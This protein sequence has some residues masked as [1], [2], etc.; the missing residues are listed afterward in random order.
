MLYSI[1]IYH[2]LVPNVLVLLIR[3]VDTCVLLFEPMLCIEPRLLSVNK[4]VILVISDVYNGLQYGKQTTLNLYKS[5]YQQ[6]IKTK[7]C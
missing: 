4:L 2:T 6:Y 5:V 7:N 1:I 3:A